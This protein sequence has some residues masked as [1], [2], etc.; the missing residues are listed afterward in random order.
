MFTVVGKHVM[1]KNPST[2]AGGM[3]LGSTVVRNDLIGTP[4]KKGHN[5]NMII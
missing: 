4:I 1:I 2:N 5:P 3:A